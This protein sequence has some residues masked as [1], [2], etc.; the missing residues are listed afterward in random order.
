MRTHVDPHMGTHVGNQHAHAYTCGQATTSPD[1]SSM[2]LSH[3]SMPYVPMSL[4][5]CHISFVPITSLHVPMS[6][7]C[8]P[9]HESVPVCVCARARARTRV[10]THT[11]TQRER[12]RERERDGP[13]PV[14]N[15]PEQGHEQRRRQGSGCRV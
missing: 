3:L 11:H 14:C 2:P 10:H 13:N 15:V 8:T 12:E 5:L 1:S 7:T 6:A 9:L 4:S